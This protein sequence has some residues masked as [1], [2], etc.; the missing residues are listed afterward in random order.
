[1]FTFA[2]GQRCNC[3]HFQG[4]VS[5]GKTMNTVKAARGTMGNSFVNNRERIKK[6]IDQEF[7]Q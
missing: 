1:M 6:T 3:L 5:T 4:Q 7:E 2:A